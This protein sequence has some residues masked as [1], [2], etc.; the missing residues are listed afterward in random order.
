[1]NLFLL[2]YKKLSFFITAISEKEKNRYDFVVDIKKVNLNDFGN[3]KFLFKQLKNYE[4]SRKSAHPF[5]TT[6]SELLR[7]KTVL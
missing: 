7:N 1:M 3:S 2:F 6:I 5:A 4:S